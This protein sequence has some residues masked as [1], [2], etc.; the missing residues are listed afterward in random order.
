LRSIFIAHGPAFKSGLVVEPFQN[1][2]I[3]HLICA[4]LKLQPASN[5][6]NLD[7]VRVMLK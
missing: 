2:H 3:Y 1:I 5:D 7:S 4:I 6:G